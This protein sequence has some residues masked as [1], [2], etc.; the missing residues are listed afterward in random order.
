MSKL[1]S[2]WQGLRRRARW[3][4]E[5]PPVTSWAPAVRNFIGYLFGIN[6]AAALP[7]LVKIDIS[8]LCSLACSHCLHADPAGRDRPLLTA[9]RFEKRH[10]MT[11]PQYRGIIDQ[12]RGH[13]VAVSL[14]YYGD[15]LSHPDLDAMIAYARMAGLAV[16]VTTHF[17]YRMSD[18]RIASLVEG[19]LSHL[20]V[21]VDGATQESYGVTRLR[22]KLDLVL[23]N[24]SR[25]V[26]HRNAH[27]LRQPFVE[28]QHLQFAH[29]PPG[30]IDRVAK[31]ARDI[32]ADNFVTYEGLRHTPDG[33]LWNVVDELDAP[34]EPP[35]ARPTSGLPRCAWPFTSTVI[36]YDGAVIPCCVWRAGSQYAVDGDDRTLG[37]VFETPL[38]TIWNGPA[39]RA[40][41]QLTKRPASGGTGS[42][43]EGCPKLYRAR[44]AATTATNVPAPAPEAA[45]R[46]AERP[47][48]IVSDVPVTYAASGEAR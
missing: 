10:R 30:E 37:N 32:G 39:Y 41:R 20:T 45:T 44:P 40:M 36:R 27:G 22:G 19:G 26:A 4:Q 46:Y 48:S 25:V 11:L 2:R 21:D 5:L 14:F 33:D 1:W 28:V 34:A 47:P 38:A 18:A 43:C 29:H 7:S 17:S 16:H 24:L 15:P 8:P 9:Q 35:Q 42:F 12:L 13:A 23:H 31:I 3:L 6:R